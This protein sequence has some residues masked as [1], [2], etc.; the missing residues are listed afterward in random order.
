MLPSRTRASLRILA[1]PIFLLIWFA[2]PARPL[3]SSKALTQYAHR[4]WGQEQGLFQPTIYSILQTHD[5]FLWLGTQDSLIRFDGVQFSPFDGPGAES[6]HN[7]LIRTLYEDHDKNLWVGSIGA[8]LGKIS[9]QGVVT[10]YTTRNGLPSDSVFCVD[11]DA[12]GQMWACTNAGLVR[13]SGAGFHTYT[14]ADGLP[15]NQVRATCDAAGQRWVAGLDFGLATWDGKRFTRY[16][17]KLLPRSEPVTALACGADGSVWAGTNAG[18]LAITAA[19]TR[20]I[21]TREGLPD[22][23]VSSVLV[24]A[25]GSVWVGTNDGITRIR[26]GRFDTY[27]TRDGLSHSLVLSLYM[28][29][30][31]TLWA[32]TKDGLDQF[33]DGNVTPYTTNEG[34]LS[35]DIGPVLEDRAGALNIG[36][37][38]RGLNIF[39]HGVFRAVT[40]H[41]GLVDNTVLSLE[42]D[43]TGDLWVGTRRGLNRLHNGH[44]IA[45]Y[46]SFG[47]VAAAAVRSLFEDNQG[48]LW[49]GTDKGLVRFE[50]DRFSFVPGA[51]DEG[52]RP[53]LALAGGRTVRLFVS[54]E[55]PGFHLLRDGQFEAR[56]LGITH[57]VDCFFLNYD[58]HSAWM[59]TL[60]SGLLRWANGKI[61]RVRIK[62]GLY[63]NRIYQ[64]LSDGRGNFWMASSKGIFRVSEDELGRVADGQARFVNSMPFSTGQLRFEC[65]SGVQPAAC[66]T[67]DGRLWFSTTNGLVVID[68]AH[69]AGDAAAPPAQITEVLVNGEHVRSSGPLALKPDQKNLEI[70]YAGLSFAS[71][72]KV[73]F[74]YKL[75]GFDKDW[76][77]AGARREAFFTNLPPKHFRFL[78]FARTAN[79]TISAAPAMIDF[80]VEPRLYQRAWFIP[81]LALLTGLASIAA[82]RLRM[83]RV[84][85][86]FDVVLAERSRI[87]RE[88]HDTLLQGLS[89]VTMQL[90][91]LWMRMPLS[92][93]KNLLGGIIEDAGACAHEARQSLRGLRSVTAQSEDF[94]E[95]LAQLCREALRGSDISLNLDLQSVGLQGLPETEFQL[96]RI[97]REVVSNTREH[98]DA[99]ALDV[100][101]SIHKGRL[102]LSFEDNGI[103]FIATNG[104]QLLDHFG[105]VG[106]RER[107]LE[108]GADLTVSSA[109][110]EG[111]KITVELTPGKSA[112]T[113]DKS[114]APSVEHQI[115]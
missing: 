74:R 85:Q 57:P 52:T 80:T 114:Q 95:L 61:D 5:G 104:I 86:R 101:L 48:T 98:A 18:L 73:T 41:D 96:L 58:R 75:D 9:P 65:R 94:S 97:A 10:H 1:A 53:V 107:A 72:E 11:S 8:G 71:P 78:V 27:R 106:I 83:K 2:G 76:I 81:L 22:N 55:G 38:G 51:T 39:E 50:R 84:R 100:R 13:F 17:N 91:A 12:S 35:N 82:Y 46:R 36:T 49:I 16:E 79:G 28:D 54:T 47:P 31:G 25:D 20:L 56:A 88:L 87:A 60:G 63:D 115:M 4:I 6:F 42:L 110:G 7:T 44:V 45:S 93:E 15:S 66:R 21:A 19:G 105:L 59:G 112:I 109:P 68:P 14:T 40:M 34:L 77:E 62:D 30:E 89:G 69:P 70:R 90:Q 99:S 29:R 67:R 103:G 108:I 24:A 3:D 92:K 23:A 43:H 64:I 111:T 33:T 102:R 26:N 37:L 113:T 32:G